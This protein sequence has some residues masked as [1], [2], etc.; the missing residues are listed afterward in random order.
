MQFNQKL[1]L[2]MKVQNVTNSR[3]AR[4][5]SVDPSL[6]SRWRTG[7]RKPSKKNNYIKEISI[8]FVSHAKMDYQKAALYE[9]MGLDINK[10]QNKLY[11]LLNLL[12]AWLANQKSPNKIFVEKFFNNLSKKR[13]NNFK[14]TVNKP[15][16]L[17]IKNKEKDFE[18]LNGIKGKR[19]GV[20]KF[21]QAVAAKKEKITILLYSNEDMEWLSGDKEFFEKWNLLIKTVIQKGHKIKI[22]HTIKREMSEMLAAIDYWMPLYLTGAI[23]PYYYPKYQENIFRRTMFV[24][25]GTAA[26]NCSTVSEHSDKAQQF[27]YWEQEKIKNLTEEYNTFLK[28]CRPLMRIYTGENIYNFNQLQIE[29]EEQQAEMISIADM[30]SFITMPESL[31]EKF[32]NK[33]N[34][35]PK[36]KKAVLSVY[37]QRHNSFTANIA[38]HHYYEI[39]KLPDKEDF[40]TKK[41]SL[42][43]NDFFSELNFNYS[44]SD[45]CEHLKH[46]I[47]LL[48]TYDNYQLLTIDDFPYHNI[49]LAVKD[50]VGAVITRND[51]KT[52]IIAFNQ[53]NITNSF[54][55]YLNYVIKEIPK[56]EKNK[57]QLID[58]LN[59][60]L[61]ALSE[62]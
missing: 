33:N 3:L 17:E 2:L 41:N 34:A 20:I 13:Q 40:L 5:L 47:Q 46:N 60:Y 39:I 56:R 45:F 15:F 29:F 36:L 49:R 1:D 10:D 14:E 38:K 55:T 27:L 25:P 51:E 6:V 31:I 62:Q 9:I 58:K 50:E 18:I 24:A 21:L 32:L 54:Y 19:K 7:D 57:K 37:K 16:D 59:D 28:R 43:T 53:P 12:Y 48:K 52:I 22:I 23:E 4:A 61:E 35:E 42:K 8:Y 44:I 30:L 26:L 11:S